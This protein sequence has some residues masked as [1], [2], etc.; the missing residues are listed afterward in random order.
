MDRQAQ[1]GPGLLPE[2]LAS[3]GVKTDPQV[4]FSEANPLSGSPCL[5]AAPKR[6]GAAHP[7]APRASSTSR[8]TSPPPESRWPE[9]RRRHHRAHARRE[10][11][12][13]KLRPPR[14]HARE[15]DVIAFVA[16]TDLERA[17]AFYEGVLGVPAIWPRKDRL[18]RRQEACG[19]V[20]HLTRAK[21]RWPREESLDFAIRR[22]PRD[23]GRT[24]PCR[25]GGRARRTRPH[26]PT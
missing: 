26:G 24:Q 6:A 14:C 25:D 23:R 12:W 22:D 18:Y 3:R 9:R 17:R 15:Q 4:P 11:R 10:L 5:A 8:K 20:R 13:S 19:V 1:L 21:A 16:P 7:P 2:M